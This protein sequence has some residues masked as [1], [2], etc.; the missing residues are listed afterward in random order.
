MATKW[1]LPHHPVVNPNKPNKVRVVF[2][3]AARCSNDL[4][5]SLIGVLTR[6]RKNRIALV[7]DIEAMF[8]QVFV[9]S[10]H[11]N[12]LRFLWWPNGCLEETPASYQ[13]LVHI[14]GAKSSPSCA[15]F[16]LRQTALD[17]AHL[18]NPTILEIVRNNFYVDDCLFSVE[19]ELV[20]R[21]I[22]SVEEAISAQRSLC[23]LFRRR[24]FHLRKWLLNNEQVIKAIPDSERATSVNNYSFDVSSHQRVLGV[25]WDIKEDQ[26]TFFINLPHN[27]FTKRGVLSTIASLYDPLGFV[28]PVVLKAKVFLQGLT[29]RK[30]GWDEEITSSES[31]RWSNWLSL[32]SR[33][34]EVSVPSCFKT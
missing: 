2:D 32:L 7:G 33:L 27:P 5:N 17:F 25:N 9:K 31:K 18:Y 4:M 12:A 16:C 23:E 26:F 10:E 21:R 20:S 6:F 34:N 8:H 3:C 30:A 22:S 24:G 1:Y 19:E 28:S 14:F 11:A 13:M 15:N 29:R